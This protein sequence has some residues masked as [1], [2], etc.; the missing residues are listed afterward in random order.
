MQVSLIY[1]SAVIA[2]SV[3][4]VECKVVT[5]FLCGNFQQLFVLH[6]R[7]VLLKV[8]VQSRATCEML[9]IWRSVHLKLVDDIERLIFHYVEVRI[10]TVTWY[11]VAILTVPLSVL[12]T[13][14]LSRNHLAV[15]ENLLGAILLV[16]FLYNR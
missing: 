5:S 15:E 14:V 10:V 3:R 9:N 7:E 6:L 4:Y 16:E 8:H 1:M 13:Y 2:D 11:E 12:D